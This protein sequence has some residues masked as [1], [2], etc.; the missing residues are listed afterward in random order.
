[1]ESIIQYNSIGKYFMNKLHENSMFEI[2]QKNKN[3]L[4]RKI[5]VGRKLVT[6]IA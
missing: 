1:M 2:N 5:I 3:I 6:L 4:W